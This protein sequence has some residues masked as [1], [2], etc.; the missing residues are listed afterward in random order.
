MNF[1]IE[2]SERL[3]G[4]EGR[5]ALSN[6]KE[7]ALKVNAVEKD[8]RALMKRPCK[9][10]KSG[11]C[12][13]GDKCKQLGSSEGIVILHHVTMRVRI[14]FRICSLIIYNPRKSNPHCKNVRW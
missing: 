6:E 2:L 1:K 14:H 8:L 12:K 4:E 13:R 5:S 7:T 11:N 10:F 9:F 3:G